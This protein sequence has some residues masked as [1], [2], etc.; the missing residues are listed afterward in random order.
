MIKTNAM[1]NTN[2]NIILIRF[3]SELNDFLRNHPKKEDIRYS[4]QGRRSIK[5]LIESFGVPHVEVDL[6]LVNGISTGFD[7]I[8]KNGDRIS[9]YP[10]FESCNIE[11]ISKLKRKALRDT[12][13]VLDVHLGKL[14][15]YLRLLGFDTDYRNFRDDAELAEISKEQQRILL[16][17][18][19]QLLMRSIVEKGL[20]IRNTD[21][22]LQIVEIL[23][24]LDLWDVV[25]P[26]SRC[27]VCNGKIIEIH[28]EDEAFI[29]IFNELPHK[30]KSWCKEIYKCTNC[31]KIYWKGSHY[32]KLMIFIEKIMNER[33]VK[34]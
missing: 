28:K 17:R 1:E 10:M 11:A 13:F 16:T 31:G 18:D 24:R 26:F 21:P 22:F 27:T 29:H 34:D 8:V 14:A 4:F 20:I 5:D 3:Y 23:N 30:V 6:I 9:V 32:D 19:R 12:K 33:K 7:Y 2:E 25:I 15:L